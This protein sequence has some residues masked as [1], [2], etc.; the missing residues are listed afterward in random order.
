MNPRARYP[1]LDLLKESEAIARGANLSEKI[2]HTVF[3]T[4][5]SLSTTIGA[6]RNALFTAATPV[7]EVINLTRKDLLHVIG[8]LASDRVV[9]QIFR[10]DF[11]PGEGL[12]L[13]CCYIAQPV[14]E[15]DTI[16]HLF[17]E[18]AAL[19]ARAVGMM[20][21]AIPSATAQS[22]RRD[23]EN[24][25]RL[26]KQ[27]QPGDLPATIV[28]PFV[29]VH[30]S[31][32]DLLP[33]PELIQRS[34]EDIRDLLLRNNAALE[35]L[36][37]GLMPQRE[38]ETLLRF[39]TAAEF[40]LEKLAPR[41]RGLGGL[42]SQL[43]DIRLEESARNLDEF[44]PPTA[45]FSIQRAQAIKQAAQSDAGTRG[46]RFAGQL[47]AELIAALGPACEIA[48]QARHKAEIEKKIAEI[49][50]R[51]T[52][53][54]ADWRNRILFLNEEARDRMPAEVFRAI[55]Q[56]AALLYSVWQRRNEGL[57]CFAARNSDAFR[58]LARGMG[59][60][61]YDECWQALAMRSLLDVYEKQFPDLFEDPEF[62]REYGRMLRNAYVH[63]MPWYYR[64][65]LQ[66]GITWF[67]DRSFQLAKRAIAAEQQ[68][69]SAQNE[70][71][72]A[73]RREQREQELKDKR[74][75]I[76]H[77]S[78]ANRI[79]EALDQS[80]IEQNLIPSVGE[81]RRLLGEPDDAAFREF[82][83]REGFQLLAP[84][85]DQPAEEAILLYPLNHEWRVRAARLRRTVDRLLQAESSTAPEM[86]ARARRLLKRLNRPEGATTE[87][88]GDAGQGDPYQRFSDELDRF[89]KRS[90]Q[91]AEEAQPAQ[92]ET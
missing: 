85:R 44:A 83:A 39:E 82:L 62:L 25:L 36:N 5:Q 64:L 66:F 2:P 22:V 18:T 49:R 1:F 88:A 21:D 76:A 23:L 38:T 68:S 87:A 34:V 74:L 3:K 92:K 53:G 71:R 48:Y 58:Q 67:Q 81:I 40:L 19:S 4:I 43:E 7:P 29:G 47:A 52:R 69:L 41:Y 9:T 75:K 27:P 72:A 35:L 56:D 54:G 86:L 59:S 13:V 37:Y 84:A 61:S 46:G 11:A 50:D 15:K 31:K 6:K 12:Q 91:H 70:A 28:D 60:L 78:Q 63:Y 20:L 16:Y 26:E 32:F 51:L 90:S 79:A 30:A 45:Q 8:R 55:S 14:D 17:S 77:S 73:S 80:Y 24:D 42:K 65:L 10:L 33:A 89:E 57:H